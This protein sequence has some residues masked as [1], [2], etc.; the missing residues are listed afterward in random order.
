[1]CIYMIQVRG[2]EWH[3]L[4]DLAMSFQL[5][6]VC[7]F[8]SF[9]YKIQ[10]Y[11]GFLKW[12]Y[13]QIT[14]KWT[15]FVGKPMV[16]GYHHFRK[17][18]YVD[19]NSIKLVWIKHLGENRHETQKTLLWYLEPTQEMRVM[20]RPWKWMDLWWDLWW[21][22]ST[23]ANNLSRASVIPPY[24]FHSRK[25]PAPRFVV[26]HQTNICKPSAKKQQPKLMDPSSCQK[27][28]NLVR[29]FQNLWGLQT[30]LP[31]LWHL[32]C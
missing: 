3:M 22:H 2:L 31:F 29:N 13:P 8:I 21:M 25:Q 16:V 10:R 28:C 26:F 27:S 18:P 4:D 11:R 15:L 7:R 23:S 14:P 12:W 17:P 24:P 19:I 20:I 5:F 32:C 9:Q 1:M 30:S 6:P